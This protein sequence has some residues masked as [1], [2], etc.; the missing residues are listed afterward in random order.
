MRFVFAFTVLAAPALAQQTWD[1]R[2]DVAACMVEGDG[3]AKRACVGSAAEKCMD[4]SEGG[5]T[6]LGMTMCTAAETAA[7]DDVLNTEFGRTMDWSRAMDAQDQA[8]FPEFAKRAEMLR[9]AQR[10]WIP[11]RDAECGFAYAQWGAGSMRHI[12]GTSCMLD[13]TATRAIELFEMREV[14]Q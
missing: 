6:T 9:A 13:M 14:M 8:H 5:Y 2:P 4:T 1:A 3:A 12:A 10:A 7:W 11:F